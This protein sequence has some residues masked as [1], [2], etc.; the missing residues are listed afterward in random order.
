MQDLK[1]SSHDTWWSWLATGKVWG[2]QWRWS[3]RMETG[4]STEHPGNDCWIQGTFKCVIN[5]PWKHYDHICMLWK[6]MINHHFLEVHCFHRQSKHIGNWPCLAVNFSCAVLMSSPA[7]C[8]PWVEDLGT[9]LCNLN[10]WSIRLPSLVGGKQDTSFLPSNIKVS[11]EISRK[12]PSN[13]SW[14][15]VEPPLWKIWVRHLGWFFRIY[16][17]IT[18]VPNHQPI[19]F[20]SFMMF[21]GMVGWIM[22]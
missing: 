17:K 21:H 20:P 19:I 12:T 22:N 18:H 16:G 15:V 7:P 2:L 4:R 14:S 5:Y 10:L 6:M 1:I 9:Q 11:C 8:N 3:L 13:Q